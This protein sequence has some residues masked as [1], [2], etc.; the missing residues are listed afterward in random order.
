MRL[1]IPDYSR[2]RAK[3]NES[4]AMLLTVAQYANQARFAKFAQS[5]LKALLEF[6]RKQINSSNNNKSTFVVVA[7]VHRLLYPVCLEI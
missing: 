2:P 4:G 1:R 7:V 6:H 5:P 3:E